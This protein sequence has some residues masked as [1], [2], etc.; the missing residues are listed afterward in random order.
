MI[1][2]K[3]TYRIIVQI[4]LAGVFVVKKVLQVRNIGYCIVVAVG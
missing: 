3:L 2:S 1:G 4:P